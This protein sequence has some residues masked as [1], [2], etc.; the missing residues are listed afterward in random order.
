MRHATHLRFETLKS[1]E[2]AAL[3]SIVAPVVMVTLATVLG[4][5]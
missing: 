4:V 2:S 1:L 5:F 3:L